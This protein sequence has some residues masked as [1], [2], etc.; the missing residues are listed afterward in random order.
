V[1]GPCIHDPKRHTTTLTAIDGVI[2]VVRFCPDCRQRVGAVPL[3]L[4]NGGRP[5]LTLIA[6]GKVDEE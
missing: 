6:G 3:D 2:N 5:A 4:D 1:T